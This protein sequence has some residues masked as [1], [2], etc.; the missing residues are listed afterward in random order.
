M[1]G[2]SS[3]LVAAVVSTAA[4]AAFVACTTPDPRAGNKNQGGSTSSSSSSTSSSSSSSGGV[5][6]ST[7]TT[8]ECGPAPGAAGAFDKKALLGAAAKCAAWHACGFQNAATKLRDAAKAYAA[9]PTDAT[10]DAARAA[11]KAAMAEQSKME[12][13]RFGPAGNTGQDPY[14]GRGLRSFVHPWPD[15][16]RC[17][18][19][20]QVAGKEWQKGIDLVLPS[21]RG[22]FAIEYVLF[23]GGADTACL[24]GSPTGQAW[25]SITPADLAKAKADY[26]VA[27][28]ENVL[29]VA[30]EL[31]NVW[32]PAPGGEDFTAKLLAFDGYGSEQETL[33]VVAWSLLYEEKEIK[34]T[35]IAPRAGV[36][37]TP[38]IPETPFALVEV[39][40]IRTNLR[41]FRTLFQGCSA[42]GTGIGFDDWLIAAGQGQLANEIL[43]AMNA[44]QAAVDAFPPFDKAT[45]QQFADLYVLM[46]NLATIM[47]TRFFGSASPLNLKLPASV[48]SDTD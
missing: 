23:Y 31:R 17:L 16:N 24:P 8:I 32:L 33:N 43:A 3:V 22:L 25:G 29:G 42:D 20:T 21:G 9:G 40:N 11:W 7:V 2:R 36:V 14:H 6:A 18:V 45:E 34:D 19:E 38:P 35:K 28:A 1:I 48:A 27:V 30:V 10:R 37:M 13:F 39:E 41:A 5:D 26:G 47:K 15:T 46:R 4:I 12:L 44:E